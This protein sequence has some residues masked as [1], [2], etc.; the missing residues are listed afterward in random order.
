MAIKVRRVVTG[1]DAQGKATFVS[2]GPAPAIQS[3]NGAATVVDLWR[4]H[5]VPDDLRADGGAL[6]GYQPLPPS[7]GLVVRV[8]ELPP[9]GPIPPGVK[10][11][12]WGMHD[13]ETIDFVV[14]L[15]GEITHRLVSGKEALLKAG[16]TLV[17]RATR[18]AWRNRSGKPCVMAVIKVAGRHR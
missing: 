11:E 1:L 12:E 8:A 17:Q 13:S 10:F 15:S 2:D 4:S 9:D 6:S 5:H 18:H 3:S 7:E 16:D 14:I